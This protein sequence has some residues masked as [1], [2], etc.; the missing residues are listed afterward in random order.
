MGVIAVDYW[1]VCLRAASTSFLMFGIIFAARSHCKSPV[2]KSL[3]MSITIIAILSVMPKTMGY[4]GFIVFFGF[5]G[6]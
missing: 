2:T 1:H 6:C 5:G 4:S 3:S